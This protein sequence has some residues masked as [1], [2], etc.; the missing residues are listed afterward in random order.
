MFTLALTTD[1]SKIFDLSLGHVFGSDD[2]SC[3]VLLDDGGNTRGVSGR[4][5]RIYMD[6]SQENPERL[7][8]QN[9]S[10][11]GT[12]IHGSLQLDSM[13]VSV[14]GILVDAGPMSLHVR[15]LQLPLTFLENWR[16]FVREVRAAVPMI[17]NLKVARVQPTPEVPLPEGRSHLKHRYC[18]GI[19]GSEYYYLQKLGAGTYGTVSKVERKPDGGIFAIKK[20]KNGTSP[21]ELNIMRTISHSNIVRYVDYCQSQ[22]NLYI[23]ME[24]ALHGDFE[25]LLETENCL[26]EQEAKDF[27][28]QVL[29]A[30]GYL[31][32]KGIVHRDIKPGNILLFS[33]LPRKY[34]LTDFGLSRGMHDNAALSF[35]GTHLYAAPEIYPNSGD[36]WTGYD[37]SVDIWSLGA[38]LWLTLTGCQM[39]E[40]EPEHCKD[41]EMVR[42]IKELWEPDMSLFEDIQVSKE[43][44]EFV[45]DMLEL[46]PSERPSAKDCLAKGWL[47]NAE[48]V[49]ASD[50]D[51]KLSVGKL[52]GTTR[53]L[54]V[55]PRP[56]EMSCSPVSA[57]G[58]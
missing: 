34:K 8:L 3:D 57:T 25:Q 46:N 37:Y 32:S 15:F 5:F 24:F 58:R 33:N 40:L 47:Y 43:G 45:I 35:V 48:Q 42:E 1:S 53:L 16:M 12:R 52:S 6:T 29:S 20:M 14:D 54:Q 9:L 30:L 22:K 44:Q 49:P 10:R 27:A 13:D 41:V 50:G 31:R 38:V 55:I 11:H 23:V 2:E 4:H 26:D 7:I 18:R 39:V 56:T 19:S 36:S 21:R 28:F 17:T 51:R